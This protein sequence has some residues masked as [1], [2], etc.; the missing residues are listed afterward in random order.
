MGE[1]LCNLFETKG[2]I[3]FNAG[4]TNEK[5]LENVGKK[6]PHIYGHLISNRGPMIRPSVLANCCL[7]KVGAYPPTETETRSHR[8]WLHF[9]G[10]VLR[11]LRKASLGCRIFIYQKVRERIYNY[12]FSKVNVL[13]KTRLEANS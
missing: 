1:I 11:S 3:I 2:K 10:M 6:N 5:V 7:Y 12:K 4:W 8:S 9:K 13:R